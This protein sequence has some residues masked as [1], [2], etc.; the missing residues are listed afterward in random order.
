VVLHRGRW[1]IES[2]NDHWNQFA[3]TQM[4]LR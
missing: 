4:A 2:G 1:G 3:Q